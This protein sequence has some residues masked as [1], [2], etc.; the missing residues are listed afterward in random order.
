MTWLLLLGACTTPAAPDPAEALAA[1]RAESAGK[2]L[3]GRLEE[4]V[5]RAL[6]EGGPVGAVD[7]CHLEAPGLTAEVSRG[8]GVR[9]GRSSLRLRNPANA[10]PDWVQAWLTAQGERPAEGLAP[11]VQVASTAEG[12]VSRRIQPI[13]IKPPCLLCHG[14]PAQVAP[15][16]RA[17]LRER[18]PQDQALGYRLGDL[19]GALWVEIP[20]GG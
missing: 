7:A 9:A 14:E 17:A 3:A 5:L 11:V 4:R 1:E 10:G 15:E 8:R 6:T 13:A 2:A 20:V 16:V 19:R 12:K 18:Y